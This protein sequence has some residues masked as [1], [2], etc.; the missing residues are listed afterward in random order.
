ML[1][2]KIEQGYKTLLKKLGLKKQLMKK[3]LE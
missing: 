2:A 3:I 1:E